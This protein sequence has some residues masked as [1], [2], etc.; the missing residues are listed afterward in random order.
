MT[1]DLLEEKSMVIGPEH[2]ITKLFSN[3]LNFF[4]REILFLP[5]D[6]YYAASKTLHKKQDLT[7]I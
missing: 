2:L 5:L 4:S 6:T 7:S 1:D 3:F